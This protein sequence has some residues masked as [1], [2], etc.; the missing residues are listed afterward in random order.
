MGVMRGVIRLRFCSNDPYD[1]RWFV[2]RRS[3]WTCKVIPHPAHALLIPKY[4]RN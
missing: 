1:F 2:L 4:E 3:N